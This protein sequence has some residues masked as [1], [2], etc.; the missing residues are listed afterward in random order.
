MRSAAKEQ[1]SGFLMVIFVLVLLT[2]VGIVLLSTAQGEVRTARADV[3]SKRAFYYAEAGAE[4]A[5]EQLRATNAADT[6]IADRK[7]FSDELAAAAGGNGTLDLNPDNLRP[8][9]DS[10]GRP[11]AFTGAGDEVPLRA[12]TNF[13]QGAYAAYL[14][15]DPAE[16]RHNLTDTNGL[17]LITAVGAGPDNSF[18]VTESVVEPFDIPMFPATITLLG[19]HPGFDG[20][21]SAAK[22]YSGNDCPGGTGGYLPAVGAVGPVA[23]AQAQLGVIKPGSYWAGPWTGANTVRDIGSTMDPLWNDCQYFLQLQQTLKASAEVVGNSSTPNTSLGTPGSPK[24]AYIEGDYTFT[25]A[26]AGFLMVTGTL[27][28]HGATSWQGVILVVGKGVLIRDGTGN[29]DILG[30]V[31]LARSAGADGIVGT[32]DD[33]AG[34]DGVMGTAD[35]G[36]NTTSADF[37]TMGGG[38]SLTEYCS[39]YITDAEWRLPLRIVSFRQR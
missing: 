36:W 14:S 10:Q 21:N 19:P 13:G 28:L 8:V 17:A 18:M 6:V 22:Q 35:D 37:D 24:V 15:N 20:G 30:A 25:G 5:R 4:D 9:F 16:G 2:G 11:T 12:F 34:D 7:T 39:K 26:G 33:C 29:G 38:T 3:L 32:A 31:L 27:T 23:V 1:G